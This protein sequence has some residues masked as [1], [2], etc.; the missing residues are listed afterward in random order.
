MK[1]TKRQPPASQSGSTG[2][3]LKINDGES[4]IGVLAGELHEFFQFWNKATNKSELVAKDHPLAKARFRA[5]FIVKEEGELRA[6]IFE[7]GMT[8][9]DQLATLSEDY[10]L[11]KT[12]LKISR[13]GLKTDTIWMITPAKD[14]PTAAQLK[15]IQAVNLNIL[16]HREATQKPAGAQIAPVPDLTEYQYEGDDLPF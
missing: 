5:N 10:D 13:R 8:V 14:Q 6:K 9:Y 12:A 2:L 4:K 7:F 3:F 1:F 11:T 15:A 16:E